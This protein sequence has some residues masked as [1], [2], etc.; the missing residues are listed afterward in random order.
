MR[1]RQFALRDIVGFGVG[2]ERILRCFFAIILS[3]ELG[4]VSV[5]VALHFQVEDFAFAGDGV[6]QKV[7]V[8]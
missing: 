7:L 5:I 2:H 6:G 8:E 3:G 4:L 1:R